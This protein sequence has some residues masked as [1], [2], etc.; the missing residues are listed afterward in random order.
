MK[1]DDKKLVIAISMMFAFVLV[2]LFFLSPQKQ[3]YLKPG[4]NASF[5]VSSLF[6]STVQDENVTA[7]F[8]GQ[9]PNSNATPNS[10]SDMPGT[11]QQK[12][13]TPLG[14]ISKL[15]LIGTKYLLYYGGNPVYI[16]S[17]LSGV[18]NGNYVI[19]ENVKARNG[20]EV[21]EAI[22]ISVYDINGK[23]IQ[24]KISIVGM[25]QYFTGDKGTI[26]CGG[27]PL[28][29]VCKE[30]ID[31]SFFDRNDT[32]VIR[33]VP[34][35]VKVFKSEKSEIWVG[36]DPPIMFKYYFDGDTMNKSFSAELIDMNYGGIR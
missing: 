2:V 22:S 28:W 30:M 26:Q 36:Y 19:K 10:L 35:K 14:D 18:T 8:Q 21:V 34:Y 17:A 20:D 32:V 6:D 23:C 16:Q 25:E 4:P 33:G 11:A 27:Y 3:D 13:C 5:E 12:N 9:T 7:S 15:M 1:L 29:V 31:S 24:K